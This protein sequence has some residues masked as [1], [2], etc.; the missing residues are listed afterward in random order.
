MTQGMRL[1][2]LAKLA[3]SEQ[4]VVVANLARSARAGGP[5]TNRM[6]LRARIRAFEARYE[7]TSAEMLRKFRAGEIRE[8]ADISKWLFLISVRDCHVPTA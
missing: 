8:T 5:P 1:F 6:V 2:D 7:M 4:Q 3:E